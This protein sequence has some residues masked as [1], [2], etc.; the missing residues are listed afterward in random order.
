MYDLQ[1]DSQAYC[2]KLDLETAHLSSKLLESKKI[3]DT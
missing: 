2:Y 3:S 1:Y